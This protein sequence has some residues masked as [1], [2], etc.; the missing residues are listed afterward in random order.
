M[1]T[2]PILLA[3]ILIHNCLPAQV[4][5]EPVIT[6]AKGQVPSVVK[7]KAN[8]IH[9]VYGTG[10]SI[11]Y[12]SGKDGK[13]F[14]SPS[15]VSVLPGL[16]SFAM[17]GPQV[18]VT[19]RGLLITACTKEGNIYIFNKTAKGQWS[20]P[21]ILNEVPACAKEG[22]MALSADGNNVFATWLSVNEPKGQKLLGIRS[23]DGGKT[24]SKNLL[25]YASPDKSVCECCKPA[26]VVKSNKVYVMFRNWL[27]GNRDLYIATST[28]GGKTFPGASK[29]GQ[30]H[31]K[32]SGCPMDGGGL[33]VSQSGLVHT[34][35][36][37]ESII[38]TATPGE[39]EQSIGEGRNCTVEIM[40][41]KPIYAWTQNGDII[42]TLPGGSKKNI[43]K[44]SLPQLKAVNDTQLFCV[45]END[46][47]IKSVLLSL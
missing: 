7:D 44:G 36:R 1:K 25:V 41:G 12:V 42:I 15:L 37:R 46:K 8:I 39:A 13:T 47:Q 32:L 18:A 6:I 34:V 29:L 30:G 23:I 31:W 4:S 11:M 16:F 5:N 35:W 9:I 43:G 2:L 22:L 3:F 27:N 21:V 26:A 40:N 19:S 14:T 17:R 24:W 20:K 38:Y 10:D 28:N 33:A 45:W